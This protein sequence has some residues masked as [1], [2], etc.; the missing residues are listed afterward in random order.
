MTKLLAIPFGVLLI[1]LAPLVLWNAESQSRALDY[2]AA[3][4]VAADAQETG[5]L[6]VAGELKPTVAIACP[7][8][9]TA[10]DCAYVNF[11]VSEYKRSE[12]ERCSSSSLPSD[13][14][15]IRQL[16]DKCDSNG[17]NCQK[18]YMV[19]N[20]NWET[21]SSEANFAPSKI[22]RFG[23]ENVSG[24]IILGEK[25]TSK[26]EPLRPSGTPTNPESFPLGTKAN[27][28]IGDK[29]IAYGY[30]PSG[31][32][33]IA[34]GEVNSDGL[35][36]NS[37]R[38]RVLSALPDSE[39]LVALQ[40]QDSANQWL[41]RFVSLAMVVFGFVMIANAISAIPLAFVKFVPLFGTKISG[42]VSSAVSFVAAAVGFLVWLL[43]FVLVMLIKNIVALL[44]VGVLLLAIAGL[45]YALVKTAKTRALA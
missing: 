25:S 42:A 33:V 21:I 19:E 6:K 15:V 23:L 2:T 13:L 40:S 18:C 35:I 14:K 27:P 11:S 30:I 1:L 28:N 44:L 43:M 31:A 7:T 10:Q 22:G 16:D 34:V 5:Y 17:A 39:T 29:E 38:I 37:N 4:P 20:K 41:L 32:K 26:Y 8:G 45:V 12:A 3:R 36:A 24:A 9:A